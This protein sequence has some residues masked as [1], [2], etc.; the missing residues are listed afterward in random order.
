VE[1]SQTV[2]P[3]TEIAGE[4][5]FPVQDWTRAQEVLKELLPAND[6]CVSSGS[7]IP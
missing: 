1:E 7:E 3:E 5:E 2:A 4:Q 6:G